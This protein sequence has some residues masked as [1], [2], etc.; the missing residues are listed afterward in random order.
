MLC[1]VV[2]G[3]FGEAAADAVAKGPVL[4]LQFLGFHAAFESA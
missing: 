1:N 4:L 2:S 3:S